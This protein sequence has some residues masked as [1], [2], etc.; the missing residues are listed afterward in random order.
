VPKEWNVLKRTD[1]SE[2]IRSFPLKLKPDVDQLNNSLHAA[3][4][5]EKLTVC[6]P[7]SN[8]LHFMEPEVSLPCSKSPPLVPRTWTLKSELL[9]TK[10]IAIL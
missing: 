6:Q 5:L 1:W 7:V 4:L 3:V 8:S 9:H 10:R 2:E